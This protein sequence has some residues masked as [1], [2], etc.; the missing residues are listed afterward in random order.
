MTDEKPDSCQAPVIEEP[1][2]HEKT[3]KY[4][5]WLQLLVPVVFLMFLCGLFL[6]LVII[7]TND[8]CSSSAP[9]LCTSERVWIFGL[10]IAG[11]VITFGI[12][13]FVLLKTTRQ[14]DY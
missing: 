11:I 8:A 10:K 2:H 5:V 9:T 4:R 6:T 14:D 13:V 1:T 12:I 3:I 7:V